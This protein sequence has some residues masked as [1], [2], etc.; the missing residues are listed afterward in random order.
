[1]R[2]AASGATSKKQSASGQGVE[3]SRVGM[4]ERGTEHWLSG[5]FRLEPVRLCYELHPFESFSLDGNSYIYNV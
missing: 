3:S 5:Y 1:M 4:E 2:R